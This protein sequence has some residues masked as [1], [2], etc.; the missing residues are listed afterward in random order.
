M[1]IGALSK[2]CELSTVLVRIHLL[3]DDGLLDEVK[4]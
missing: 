2:K 4:M 1:F 3:D